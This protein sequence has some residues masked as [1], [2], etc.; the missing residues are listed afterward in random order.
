MGYPNKNTPEKVSE[1][2][3]PEPNS[4]CW[5]FTGH[6]R[7]DGYGNIRIG[8]KR[9]LA[10]RKFYT[11]Y[12]GEIPEGLDVLH[13]CDNPSCVNPAHLFTGTHAENMA[14]M[15]SKGRS[16]KQRGKKPANLGKRG[17]ETSCFGRTGDKHP[18][19]GKH[20]TEE[21]RQKIAQSSKGRKKSP[22]TIEKV[23]LAALKQWARYRGE[24]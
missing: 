9:P 19:F 10:H 12:V 7:P 23:R 20:H 16:W 8:N 15:V 4:G 18:M 6:I 5:L 17:A 21:S 14:D 3:E 22:E 24:I 2:Y 13:K 1:M 11:L